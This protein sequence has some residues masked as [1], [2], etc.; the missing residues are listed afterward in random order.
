MKKLGAHPGFMGYLIVNADGIPIRRYIL[1]YVRN[2]MNL[3]M[4]T[5]LGVCVRARV[6][7]CVYERARPGLLV[8]VRGPSAPFLGWPGGSTVRGRLTL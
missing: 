7:V 2:N 6:C 5:A 8:R 3:P 4:L 1:R